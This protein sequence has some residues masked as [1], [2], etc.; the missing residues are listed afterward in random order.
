MKSAIIENGIVINTIV[1]E[2]PESIP[3]DPSVGI[4]WAYNGTSFIAPVQPLSHA[5]TK[6]QQEAARQASY[7]LEA[8]P[9][10]FKWQRGSATEQ[11]WLDMIAEIKLR[12]PYPEEA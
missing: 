3:C 4:G 9:L 8:D 2:L 5:P 7:Q 10:F 1:G 12:Y 6:E 11:E